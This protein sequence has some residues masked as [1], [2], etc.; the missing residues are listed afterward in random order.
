MAQTLTNLDSANP[1]LKSALAAIWP[2]VIGAVITSRDT[3]SNL[4]PVNYQAVSTAYESPLT[5]VVGLSNTS[6]SLQTLLQTHEFT[7]AYPASDQLQ[8]IIYCGTTSGSQG[9]KLQHTSLQFS[10]GV[11]SSVPW[12]VGAVLNY[13]CKV[14]H[15]YNAGGYTI[16]VGEALAVHTANQANL[17]KLYSFGNQQYGT[18]AAGTVLQRGR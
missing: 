6:Y 9:D 4:C 10:P 3:V 1:D 15:S 14:V 13:E 5:V 12:L 16:V 7:Y 2:E 8:D 17:K 11:R 18:I